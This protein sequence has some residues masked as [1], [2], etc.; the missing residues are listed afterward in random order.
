MLKQVELKKHSSVEL[1]RASYG[2]HATRIPGI[3][4][5]GGGCGVIISQGDR[6]LEAHAY[7][8]ALYGVEVK[9]PQ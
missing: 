2:V 7:I 3:T 6:G 8:P 9:D 5:T 4:K 1:I